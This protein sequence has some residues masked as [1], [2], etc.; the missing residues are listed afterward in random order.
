MGINYDKLF[1]LNNTKFTNDTL[2]IDSILGFEEVLFAISESII[3]YR[4]EH[5]LTQKDLAKILKVNQTMISKLESGDY[6]PTFKN[7][8][9]I[10]MAL[11]NSSDMFVDILNNIRIK[12]N[13]ISTNKYNIE[14]ESKNKVSKLYSFSKI[15]D[16]KIIKINYDSNGGNICYEKC[17]SSISNVG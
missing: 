2:Q 3:N 1:N 15:K 10:S 5:N 8:Y 9:N 11:N 6:N 12:I 7:I 13:N 4:K 14:F 16:T 17:T